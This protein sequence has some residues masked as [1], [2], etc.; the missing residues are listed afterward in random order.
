[1]FAQHPARHAQQ[2]DVVHHVQPTT[3]PRVRLARVEQHGHREP[4]QIRPP[5]RDERLPHRRLVVIHQGLRPIGSRRRATAIR[6]PPLPGEGRRVDRGN[7]TA[8]LADVLRPLR[9]SQAIREL[10]EPRLEFALALVRCRLGLHRLESR[11]QTL[12]RLQ[13]GL[14]RRRI[15]AA[16][17]EFDV[18]VL[19]HA[20]ERRVEIFRRH[21]RVEQREHRLISARP[22]VAHIRA[23]RAPPL[24]RVLDVLEFDKPWRHARIHRPLAQQMRAE[25]VN[26]PRKQPLDPR[27]RRFEPRSRIGV[28]PLRQ[29]AFE[30]QLEPTAQLR[31]G[32][33]RERHRRHTLDDELA[34]R[35]TG[36]HAH[37]EAVRLA[38]S[39]ARLD[40]EVAVELALEPVAHVLVGRC[41][42]LLTHGCAASGT[43]RAP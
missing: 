10:N 4:M 21:T 7:E 25:R 17:I 20:R 3:V 35:D 24:P 36:S 2:V 33:A 14:E 22:R 32:L 38:G 18:L 37:R 29:P 13:R 39:R 12:R 30:R 1:M 15:P 11:Q 42:L 31:R 34:R 26:R 6:P 9:R 16:A 28:W 41:L 19:T 40:Q 5:L 27:Q 8:E 23:P 43:G